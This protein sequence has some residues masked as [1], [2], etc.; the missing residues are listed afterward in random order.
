MDWRAAA[1][2]VPALT[3]FS[4]RR[5]AKMNLGIDHTIRPSALV[6]LLAVGVVGGTLP[7]ND[8]VQNEEIRT[9]V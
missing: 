7:T 2:C 1:V 4:Y 3:S 8:E 9:V 6:V 5:V